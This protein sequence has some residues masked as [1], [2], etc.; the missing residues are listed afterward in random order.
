MFAGGRIHKSD[1]KAAGCAPAGTVVIDL[2]QESKNLPSGCSA[3][4]IISWMFIARNFSDIPSWGCIFRT[5]RDADSFAVT[6]R[7]SRDNERSNWLCAAVL[8]DGD[9]EGS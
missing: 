5:Y 4:F 7:L 3:Q 1:T 9:S 6:L 2:H 8:Q